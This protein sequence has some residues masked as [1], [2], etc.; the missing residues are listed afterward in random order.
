MRP[1]S[2]LLTAVW[3]ALRLLE[4]VRE[5]GIEGELAEWFATPQ[6]RTRNEFQNER[7]TAETVSSTVAVGSL[8]AEVICPQRLILST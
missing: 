6:L 1:L 7:T 3:L 5:R 2:W 4:P 8:E